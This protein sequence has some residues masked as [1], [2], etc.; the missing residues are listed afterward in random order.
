MIQIIREIYNNPVYE[1]L[2]GA[3][4]YA[5]QEEHFLTVAYLSEVTGIS[6]TRIREIR[7]NLF[8]RPW[9]PS[10]KLVYSPA[11]CGQDHEHPAEDGEWW[12]CLDCNLCNFEYHPKMQPSSNDP[13]PEPVKVYRP[14]LLR[15][16]M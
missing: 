8:E 7:R 1:S 5:A 15:G 2:I 4:L 13:E 10:V 11:G 12:V 6:K 14:G 3:A 16:G 9:I